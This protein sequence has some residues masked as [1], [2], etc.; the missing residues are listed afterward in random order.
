MIDK[1]AVI[2]NPIAHSKSP[3]IHGMFAQQT[4]DAM[5][6]DSILSPLDAFSETVATFQQQG[7]K[8]LNVTV[9]F[10]EQAWE[11][12]D[13]LTAYAQAAGAVNTLV[14]KEDGRI[15]GANTDGIGLIRDLTT[16][17]AVDLSDKRVL[18]LGAGG[19]AKGVVQPLLEGN[20]QQLVIA[21]RTEERAETLAT[22]FTDIAKKLGSEIEGG[23]YNAL[24]EQGQFDLIINATAA[25]LQGIMPPMP[26]SCLYEQSVCYDLMYG[27]RPTAFEYWC[28]D[29]GAALVAN[30][31]GMLVEQAAESYAIWRGK[32]PDTKPV[33]DSLLISWS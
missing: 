33:L 23:S 12:A 17:Y 2:G 4:D 1:Y 5:S 27:G 24:R 32:Q 13:E 25:S 22:D 9:P 14:F 3:I 28:E 6:Y 20:I 8:G 31:L 18:L 15:V 29:N 30:G 7:G 11:L 26:A 16:R 21:N 19:A 10:K